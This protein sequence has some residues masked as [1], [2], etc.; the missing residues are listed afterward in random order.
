[1]EELSPRMFSFNS[2]Y[3]ACPHCDGLGSHMEIDPEMVVPDKR[4][5]LIQG[6]ITPLGEQPRGNWYGSILKSLSRH[7]SFNFTTPWFKLDRGI[8]EILLNGTGSTKL[9]MEYSS[10]RWSGTYTGGWEGTIPN[11]MRRYKQTKSN[12]IRDWIEQFMS[13]RPCPEC[14]GSRLKEESRAVTIGNVSFCLLYT[15]DAADE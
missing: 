3:G 11:L 10:E 2:P 4:K 6:A 13:M 1:M 12:H 5:S 9:K 15:S 7:Y 8:R 14:N